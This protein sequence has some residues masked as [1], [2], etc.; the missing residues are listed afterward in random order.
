[1][2]SGPSLLAPFAAVVAEFDSPVSVPLPADVA[3]SRV[4]AL[5]PQPVVQRL[6]LPSSPIAFEELVARLANAAQDMRGPCGL[7]V[8]ASRAGAVSC[9][10]ALGYHDAPTALLALTFALEATAFL[11][12]PASSDRDALR[13]IT[14]TFQRHAAT[15]WSRQPDLIARALMRVARSR[16]I[17]VYPVSPGSRIWMYGQGAAGLHFLEAGNHSDSLTGN[18]LQR[19]KFLSNQL[20]VRLGLPGVEHGIATHLR[21]ASLIAERLGFPVVVKPIDS[22]KGKGVSANIGDAQSLASAFAKAIQV[23]SKGVLVERHVAGDDHRIA[24]FGGRTAWVVQRSAPRVVG[25]GQ[26]TV[27]QL[28]EQENLERCDGDVAAGF[29]QRLEVDPDMLAELAKQGLTPQD[30]PAAGRTVL[31]RS[32]ANLATG[33]TWR[34]RSAEIHP[35]NREMAETIA[36]GFHMDSLGI[37][38]ITTDI[39]RSWREGACAVI[40]VNATPGISSDLHAEG[41]LRHKFPG[42]S[43]GR[44]PSVV[45]IGLG[46]PIAD[47]IREAFEAAGHQTGQTDAEATRLRGRHF[48]PPV[49]GLPARVMA[50]LLDPACTAL[51]IAASPQ[52]IVEHGFP[53]DRCDLAVVGEPVSGPMQRLIEGCSGRV[54]AGVHAGNADSLV[55]P[56]VARLLDHR[57]RGG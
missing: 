45:C 7:P 49:D 12:A 43:D 35:D 13:R 6:M 47:R 21:Q 22:G 55:L 24:V 57:P 25:D 27:A 37:D 39:A 36:R 44:V 52:D 8:R 40:E 41:I 3:S 4:R 30:R 53:L 32:V 19:D 56:Q 33:G 42:G 14:A 11:F 38:F 50:L 54:I 2:L 9:R 46:A 29:L 28:I 34:D 18:L 17:P 23:S 51:V 15:T 1:M 26:H 16:G 48:A 5:I 31:L 10:V 20:I